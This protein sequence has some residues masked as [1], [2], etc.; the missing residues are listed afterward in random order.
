MHDKPNSFSKTKKTDKVD[1]SKF[2]NGSNIMIIFSIFLFLSL[3]LGWFKNIGLF[4]LGFAILFG[5]SG[6]FLAPPNFN[7]RQNLK[8]LKTSI[9]N[10]NKNKLKI[11]SFISLVDVFTYSCFSFDLFYIIFQIADKRT[12][13]LLL[14]MFVILWLGLLI[15]P[16]FN[17]VFLKK[18]FI[19]VFDQQLIPIKLYNNVLL[20]FLQVLFFF[21]QLK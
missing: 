6:Y 21:F 20:L 15:V 18:S 2:F 10:S 17:L 8:V 3:I 14:S 13:I 12:F 11:Y 1:H 5:F 7:N 19:K 4:V 9:Y 16:L